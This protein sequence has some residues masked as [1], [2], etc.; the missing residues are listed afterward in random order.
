MG[1][2][3]DRGSKRM[4]G[5]RVVG[6]VW[7]VKQVLLIAALPA[8]AV[9]GPDVVEIEVH[10]LI[11]RGPLR[12]QGKCTHLSPGCQRAVHHRRDVTICR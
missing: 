2:V 4:V 3:E 6:Q 10:R 7:A 1:G 8:H 9:A 12:R 11:D 5:I